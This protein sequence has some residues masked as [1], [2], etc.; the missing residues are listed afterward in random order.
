MSIGLGANGSDSSEVPNAINDGIVPRRNGRVK[1]QPLS[2][3]S[4]NHSLLKV[5]VSLPV[6]MSKYEFRN[7][8]SFGLWYEHFLVVNKKVNYTKLQY[9][10]SKLPVSR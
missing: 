9:Q 8:F 1:G 6:W 5:F 3:C 2:S 10:L 7:L 4:M